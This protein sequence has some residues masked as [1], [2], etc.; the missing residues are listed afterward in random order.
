MNDA[1]SSAVSLPCL[2][3]D[4]HD[5]LGLSVLRAVAFDPASG[6]L[7]AMRLEASRLRSVGSGR[8]ISIAFHG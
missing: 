4:I 1:I 5:Q 8:S 3:A 6:W 2:V 7:T